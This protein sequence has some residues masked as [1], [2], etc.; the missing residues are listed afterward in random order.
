VLGAAVL[1]PDGG[2]GEKMNNILIFGGLILDRYFLVDKFPEH[3][4][5]GFIY[6]SFDIAGGCA[7]N[8][9]KTI[10]NLGGTGYV[11]SYIGQ[12]TWGTEICEYMERQKLP[13]DCVK[14]IKGKTGYCLVFVESDGERTFLTSKGIEGYF[15]DELI[16]GKVEKNCSVA[17]ITGYY[18]LDETAEELVHYLGKLKSMGY[19]IIFDPS[20]LIDKINSEILNG[21]VELSDLIIPNIQEAEYIAAHQHVNEWA[22]TK[23]SIGVKVIIKKGSAGGELFQDGKIIPYSSFLADVVDTTGAGDSFTGAISYCV[24]RGIHLNKAIL[25]AAACASIITTIKGPHGD[26]Y[27]TDLH[28][29]A[30]E[31]FKSAAKV[32]K[33]YEQSD[34]KEV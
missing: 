29:K 27:I 6:D 34:N 20:P 8:M 30:Q 7:I 16:S 2:R 22:L 12:D 3:S 15:S 4:K 5:D 21:V 18:L 28:E 17:V 19:K 14:K 26:F 10:Q 24:S 1:S 23:N 13:L 9:A 11:V 25:I 33:L 31:I 32:E